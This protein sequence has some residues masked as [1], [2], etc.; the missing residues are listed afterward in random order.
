MKQKA[1]VR[2]VRLTAVV[3]AALLF[4][5]GTVVTV[6]AADGQPSI[7]AAPRTTNDIATLLSQH[8]PDQKRAE[9]LRAILNSKPPQTVSDADQ[10]SYHLQRMK[11]AKEAGALDVRIESARKVVETGP[12][13]TRGFDMGQV[14]FAEVE[15]GSSA[16][17]LEHIEKVLRYGA[18]LYGQNV[19]MRVM[20]S[21][22][23]IDLGD[24]ENA[25]K[26]LREADQWNNSYR[27]EYWWPAYRYTY[28]KLIEVARARILTMQ[29]KYAEAEAAM[30]KSVDA[31]IADIATI[32]MK[33]VKDE[34]FVYEHSV[35]T[36]LADLAGVL[37]MQGRLNEA[38]FTA[39]R[40]LNDTVSR[41]GGYSFQTAYILTALIQILQ[42]QGRYAE[43]VSLAKTTI[44]IFTKSGA[45]DDAKYLVYT[46]NL[47]ASALV[48][49]G[50]YADALAEYH[51]IHASFAAYPESQ[52]RLAAGNADWALALVQTGK[53]DEAL[54]MLDRIIAR[55]AMW[56]GKAH[57]EIAIMTGVKGMALVASGQKDAA[58]AQFRMAMP[59]LLNEIVSPS[60][61]VSPMRAQRLK[62]IMEAYLSLLGR[63]KVRR[64]NNLPAWI[65]P[66][67]PSRLPTRCVDKIPSKP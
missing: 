9:E 3:F 66:A 12:F 16:A 59:I 56:L 18:M 31:A 23:Y 17:A 7:K 37:A 8:Q 57:G 29:G 61:E 35:N 44:D 15:G 65:L 63:A 4:L 51:R 11:A 47:L 34:K 21:I 26:S 38:E 27:N 64:S 41:F 22:A 42:Q 6:L 46:R 48:A 52:G 32:P 54:P 62:T 2:E 25:S 28:E 45:V 20:Q 58:F 50:N 36:R 24:I 53:P 40:A 33:S 19:N 39:R 49:Q 43:A 1:R 13:S 67:M 10:T 60:D 5:S 55:N 30:R 14:I